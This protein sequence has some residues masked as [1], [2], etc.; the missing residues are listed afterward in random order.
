MHDTGLLQHLMELRKRL[1]RYGCVLGV[2]FLLACL[3]ADRLMQALITPITQGLGSNTPLIATQVASPVMMSFRLAGSMAF[4]LSLPYLFAEF[5]AFATPGLYARERVLARRYVGFGFILATLG[6]AFAF[7]LI[8]PWLFYFFH[9]YLP[10]GVQYMPD[11]T[12]AFDFILYFMGVFM[13]VFQIPLLCMLLVQ[14][15]LCT[16]QALLLYRPYVIVL[17]FILGMLF[18]PPDVLSQIALALPLW[19][20]YE[21]GLLL[22]HP[23][24]ITIFMK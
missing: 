6:A 22:T 8:L 18:T 20:L 1:I 2:L 21:L 14:S 23:R 9:H 19:G 10:P 15:G 3:F 17:A 24:F 7:W 12:S 11:I 5:W 16:R 4:Y 13:L